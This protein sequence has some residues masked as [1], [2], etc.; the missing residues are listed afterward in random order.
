MKLRHLPSVITSAALSFLMALGSIGCVATA[1]QLDFRADTLPLVCA[2]CS[3]VCSTAFAFR[4]G[5][6]VLACIAALLAG[7]LWRQGLAVV[8]FLRLA[9]NISTTYH[10][11]Y[12]SIVIGSSQYTG[13]LTL[14][15]G[16]L[17]SLV[18]L[19]VSWTVSRR[20]W[21][22]LAVT[23][24]L[25]PLALC[26]VVTNTIPD[27]RYL[28][29]LL[30]GLVL[31][32]LTQTVRRRSRAQGTQ[33]TWLLL[34]PVALALAALFTAIPETDFH[35][36]SYA[37]GIRDRLLEWAGQAPVVNIDVT[38]GLPVDLQTN[39]AKLVDLRYI[40]PKSQSGT[41]VMEVSSD[42]GGPLY[43]RGR[44]YDVY[45]GSSWTSSAS[46]SEVFPAPPET[47]SGDQNLPP[48]MESAGTLTVHTFRRKSMKYLP[49]YPEDRVSLKGGMLE[50]EGSET[51]YSFQRMVLS[52]DW[53]QQAA[54]RLML[55]G[56]YLPGQSTAC[57]DGYLD[58]PSDTAAWAKSYLD[59][60][61]P[62]DTGSPEGIFDT[63]A[64]ANAIAGLV[65]QSALYSLDT[66]RMPSGT[67]D[68]ARWFLEESDTGYCVHFAT[69]TAVLLRAAGIPSRYVEGYLAQTEA[70]QSVTV[71]EKDAHAWVEYYVYPVGWIPLEST[72]SAAGEDDIPIWAPDVSTQPVDSV[73][74]TS[75]S[76]GHGDPPQ[77]PASSHIGTGEV[78]L[79]VAVLGVLGVLAALWLQWLL[80]VTRR[81]WHQ[82]HGT[83]N[84]RAL[85]KWQDAQ[86]LAR[87]LRETPP[88]ELETLALRAKFSQHTITESEL[89]CFDAFRAEAVHRL[90]SRPW[91]LRI[92]YRLMW[93]AY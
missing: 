17:S 25:L 76:E 80:R 10:S 78:P 46:R 92:Y 35:K 58:L 13:T 86:R 37:E 34:L 31:L 20:H 14:C 11:A 24:S 73:D 62:P 7:Y 26:M 44:D 63:A 55:S 81:K 48:F 54:L 9:Y 45:S 47:V 29:A 89:A 74:E 32:L 70:G 28:Y 18:S 36:K 49:Y 71:T 30:L 57:P 87:L 93:A 43:L 39:S 1:F 91:I 27:T 6:A 53:P 75:V 85:A 68:F 84:S 67:S 69:A 59:E 72:A 4:R 2:A 42:T 56:T 8:Q 60:F 61:L 22:V 65:R 88:E 19:A 41:R 5:G 52:E 21:S 82:S 38:V 40:G 90:R 77:E 79:L 16:I 3:L 66:P 64:A 23:V 33:L 83:S 50:N 12:G 51:L 15:L